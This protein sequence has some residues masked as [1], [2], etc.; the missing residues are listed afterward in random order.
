MILFWPQEKLRSPTWNSVSF[1]IWLPA[2]KQ[3][4][5]FSCN[6][7]SQQLFHAFHALANATPSFLEYPSLCFSSTHNLLL[8]FSS[9]TTSLLRVDEMSFYCHPILPRIFLCHHPYHSGAACLLIDQPLLPMKFS[10]R[11]FVSGSSEN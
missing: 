11:E 7:Y 2:S 8:K 4:L 1:M 6:P 5:Y 3:T 10:K 9:G